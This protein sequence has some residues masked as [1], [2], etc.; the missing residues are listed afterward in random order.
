MKRNPYPLLILRKH[1]WK[2]WCYILH[3]L[4]NQFEFCVTLEVSIPAVVEFDSI[5]MKENE[6]FWKEKSENYVMHEDEEC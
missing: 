4:K 5:T 6:E 3:S 2:W 1:F